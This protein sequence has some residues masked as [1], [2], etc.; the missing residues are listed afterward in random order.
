MS[1]DRK[2]VE[3]PKEASGILFYLDEP[4]KTL[5]G[6]GKVESWRKKLIN[7]SAPAS[8]DVDVV[9]RCPLPS[10]SLTV[11]AETF[12]SIPLQEENF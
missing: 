7:A 6:E 12:V 2:A 1:R 3:A 11:T 8:V 5:K 10:R 9:C 4:E